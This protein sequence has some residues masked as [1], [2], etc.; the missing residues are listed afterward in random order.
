[1]FC[2][3]CNAPDTKV[4][5]SRL[6]NE[7]SAVRR[8]RECV[9][10]NERFTTFETVELSLPLVVKRDG[11]REAFSTEKLRSG[12]LH[13]LQ[14]RPVS[15]EQVDT[16]LNHIIQ[17]ARASGDREISG[18]QLG[19]WVME[20]LRTLDAIAYVR[21]A[22]VYRSFDDIEAFRAALDTLTQERT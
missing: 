22:S 3:F 13:A 5:D 8:R 11:R 7:G 6:V 1:M 2:P 12:M 15:Q 21:F 16:S 17:R 19:E 20:A 14:K 18:R 4:I 10:C 9:Q